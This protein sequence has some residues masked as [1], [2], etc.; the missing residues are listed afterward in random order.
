MA[1][2]E[3]PLA[4]A[5]AYVTYFAEQELPVLHDTLTALQSL[6]ERAISV[7]SK[8]IAAIVL[9]DPLMTIRV[10]SW[11][12]T[13]RPVSQNQ[14]ITTISRA[15]MMIGVE[16]LMTEF[17]ALPTLENQL[18]R[19]PL[20][21]RGALRVTERARHAAYHARE[22]AILRHDLDPDE[23]TVA[24]LLQEATE[25]MFWLFAPALMTQVATLQLERPGLRSRIAQQRV[26]GVETHAIQRELVRI[27]RLPE[28]LITLLDHQCSENPRVRTVELA[29]RFA[30]HVATGWNDAGLPDDIDD[31]CALLPLSRD[32]L[33]ERLGAPESALARL[34]GH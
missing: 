3:M 22:W 9:G 23:V 29:G 16:R 24:T 28:L 21:L 6:G 30:R 8:K 12:Q 26:F 2:I 18:A 7:N 33:L 1:M 14:D 32:K 15:I 31:L 34:S 4:S 10:L 5:N 13:H 27:W 11:Q 25:I 17:S 20:A 19:Y